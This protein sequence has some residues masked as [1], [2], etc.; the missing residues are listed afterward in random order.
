MKPTVVHH[1]Q[2]HAEAGGDL[3]SAA[4]ESSSTLNSVASH[5]LN[6]AQPSES[7]AGG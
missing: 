4:S 7:M 6:D 3:G 2:F 5:E 1:T